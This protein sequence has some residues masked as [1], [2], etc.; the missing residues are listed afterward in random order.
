MSRVIEE[1]LLAQFAARPDATAVVSCGDRLTYRE[2]HRRAASVAIALRERGVDRETLVGMVFAP[3]V[4]AIV[5]TAGIVLSGGAYVPVNPSFPP[6]RVR[7]ILADSGLRHVVADASVRAAIAD[8][9]PPGVEVHDFAELARPRPT[10]ADLRPLPAGATGSPLAYV[11]YTSGSTG[12][13]KGVMIEHSGVIRLVTDTDYLDFGPHHRFLQTAALEFD[14]STLE[15]W[16]AL[17]N[18]AE[19]HVVDRETAV[20]PWRYAA[21]LREHQ[22]TVVWLT[23]PLFNQFVDEDPTMFAPLRALLTGGDVVSPGHLNRAREHNPHLRIYNGYGPTENTTFTTVFP[24]DREYDGP[25][26]IGRPIEGTTVRVLDERWE[27]VPDGEIGQLYAGGA[28]VARGYLNNAELTAARFVVLDGQRYY[29]TG[30]RVHVDSDGVLHFHGRTDDQVKIRG[31]LVEVKE[32]NLALLSVPGVTDAHTQPVGTAAAGRRLIAYVVADGV[33]DAAIDAALRERLPGFMCPDQFVRLDRLPLNHSGKVDWREL[34]PPERVRRAGQEQ[35]PSQRRL[36]DLW[37]ALLAIPAEAIGPTDTFAGLGGD[38]IRLGSLLGRVH[39]ELGVGLT[40]AGTSSTQT[41]AAM[42]E[43]VARAESTA[44]PPIARVPHGAAA[45]PHPA[46]RALYAIWQADP[47]SLAY[48]IPIR[49]TVRGPLDVDRLRAA[50]AAVVARHDALRMRLFS[51]DGVLAQVPV[52]NAIPELDYVDSQD[53]LTPFVRPFDLAAPPL[54]R[55]RLVRR[56]DREHDLHLDVHHAVFDGVSL[57]ILVDE[58][59]DLYGGAVLPPPP[60]RYADA[61]RWYHDRLAGG[62]YAAQEAYWHDQLRDPPQSTVPTDRPR[63]PRRAVRGS[64]CRRVLGAARRDA[65][66]R[67]ARRLGVTSFPVLL[68]AYAATLARLSGQRDLVV[69]SPVSGRTHP[70]VEP[71]VGMFVTTVCLRARL[72]ED[73]TL[74]DLVRQ[75]HRRGEEALAH[76]DYPFDRLAENLP[77]DPA[78]N[79]LFDALFALQNIEFYEFSKA[80]LALTVELENPATTRFDLNLQAYLRP[81]RLV[82]DLEYAT[83]LFEP[84]SADH[85]LDQFLVALN[86]LVDDPRTR[87]FAPDHAAA[88]LP[89]PD[90]AF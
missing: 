48:N 28:G 62:A 55:A 1:H 23:A 35:T 84:A 3:S 44:V 50:L 30:D 82:L 86:E 18:G 27:P 33:T 8:C 21:A 42:A 59:F 89:L 58:L 12:R 19:L 51:Q 67:T 53:G 9:A 13:P 57:R 15:I 6:R 80:D 16:G 81:D 52:D 26:P 79:P 2:L 56:G 73:T 25:V 32:V 49:V 72:D 20:V 85:L 74:A 75:L 70:D 54:I 77:R 83:D 38:S 17:L 43:A 46:Q 11:M 63:G 41:L 66:N 29:R 65:V 39:R 69:G 76:Q 64:V 88:S 60:V 87:V 34:P 90:F 47:L 40:F 45:P 22:I 10:A 68:A 71:V 31:N 36:A 14:A 24:V 78:R 5:A 7:E 37:S 4:A 61:A